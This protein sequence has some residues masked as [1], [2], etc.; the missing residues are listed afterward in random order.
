MSD[1]DDS[2]DTTPDMPVIES[3]HVRRAAGGNVTL[4][5]VA[6]VGCAVLILALLVAAGVLALV[7]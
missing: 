5:D 2:D 3:P 1:D 4:G 6:A 7:Y